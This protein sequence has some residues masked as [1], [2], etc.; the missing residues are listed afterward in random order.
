MESSDHLAAVLPGSS[1]SRSLAG[2]GFVAAAACLFAVNGTV[3]K[4]VLESGVSAL[5]L[6]E[7]RSAGAA[8]VLCLAALA[9]DRRSLR[10]A[11]RDLLFLVAYGVLGVALVQWL[12]FVA[13]AR[14][15]VSV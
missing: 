1:A 14:I 2:V 15:P 10:L 5:H 11:R 13:I 9:R 8:V 12:Y 7:I 4:L 3:S 6:V